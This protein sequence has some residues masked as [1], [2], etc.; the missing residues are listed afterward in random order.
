M[1]TVQGSGACLGCQ[2]CLMTD[3]LDVPGPLRK[4]ICMDQVCMHCRNSIKGCRF[5][6]RSQVSKR[7]GIPTAGYICV[8]AAKRPN[9]CLL[10][11]SSTRHSQGMGAFWSLKHSIKEAAHM[12]AASTGVTPI[13]AQSSRSP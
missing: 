12:P 6:A 8:Q 11:C 7:C 3:E 5:A 9:S 4:Q 13:A 10:T 2:L 1:D